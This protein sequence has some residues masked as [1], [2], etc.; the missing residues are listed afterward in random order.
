M[1]VR[2][3]DEDSADDLPTPLQ[4][5]SSEPLYDLSSQLRPKPVPLLG[6][7]WSAEGGVLCGTTS[8]V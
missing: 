5:Q 2:A 1:A 4:G 8:S 3:M 7:K 6:F